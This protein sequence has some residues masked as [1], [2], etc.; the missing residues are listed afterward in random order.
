MRWFKHMT[1]T[2]SDEKI[3]SLISMAGMEGYGFYWSIIEMVA[4]QI[5]KGSDKCS[6]TY[7]L[8][9]LSRQL[10]LHHNKVSN[11]LGKLQVTGLILLSK[12]E[13]NG[14]VSYTITC[15]NLLK[16]RDEYSDRKAKEK[17]KNRE[18]LPT[19]SRQTPEQDTDTDTDTDTDLDTD[20]DPSKKIE[21]TPLNLSPSKGKISAD[22]KQI[23]DF[24]NAMGA[25][26]LTEVEKMNVTLLI[27]AGCKPEDV[28]AARAK[29][30]D[31]VK[32][33]KSE[34]AMRQINAARQIRVGEIKTDAPFDAMTW[35]ANYN[36]ESEDAN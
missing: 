7:P 9:Y 31:Y 21:D 4:K 8:P 13:V 25:F 22:K 12:S 15:P 27:E 1:D 10:Y 29:N 18:K 33:F 20:T 28:K 19:N 23:V 34:Y 11:L 6:V 36:P 16:Y 24:Q 30:P 35:L 2:K 3:A 32:S 14:G 5:D 17:L 26:S